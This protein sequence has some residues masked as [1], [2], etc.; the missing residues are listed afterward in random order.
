MAADTIPGLPRPLAGLDLASVAS[1]L[2][3]KVDGAADFVLATPFLH[4]L[5]ASAPQ[6]AVDLLVS[7]EAYP[8]ARH[9]P[10]ADR[11]VAIQVDAQGVASLA[12]DDPTTR[13]GVLE[14]LRAAS[15]GLAVIPRFDGDVN[16]G[17][18]LAR[19]SGAPHIVG[20]PSHAGSVT[21]V[22]ERQPGAHEVEKLLDLL[23][24]LGGRAAGDRLEL[25]LPPSPRAEELRGS[26]VLC[27]GAG[28]PRRRLPPERLLRLVE[29]LEARFVVLG[30]PEDRLAADLLARSL[31][32]CRSLAGEVTLAEAG[33]VIAASAG[34]VTM[35][36]AFAQ[37]AAALDK[38]V[39][40]LS[41]HPLTGSPGHEDSPARLRPWRASRSLV[42]QPERALW[43]CEAGCKAPDTHC[44]AGLGEGPVM[45]SL[46][47]LFG[48]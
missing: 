9:S 46:S 25:P 19:Q 7:P 48:S 36:N 34:V 3:V 30:G 15:Y 13:A 22:L 29:G 14:S 6:A 31:P 32:H 4:G 11:V 21:A 5:R 41:C 26:I 17:G 35:E 47:R 24:F 18:A 2:V 38:P 42:V 33:A 45:R 1:I 10:H 28:L 40:V 12:S 39:A 43:P 44:I 27:P 37:M 16:G 20:F 23:R 8:L